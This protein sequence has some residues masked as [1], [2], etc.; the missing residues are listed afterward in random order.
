MPGVGGFTL[1]EVVMTMV[2][3]SVGL[4]SLAPVM[5][6]VVQGNRFAQN[7]TLATTLA[8]DR[9]EE[10]LNHPV[11]AQI[12]LA[13]YPSEAQG[14]IRGG[15]PKFTRF[16]RSVTVTDSLDVLGRSL[17]KSVTVTVTW[18]RQTGQTSQVTLHSRVSRF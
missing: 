13:N 7:I 5:L 11:Y 9:L 10:I 18:L 3:L 8:E 15:D 14:Q 12:T 1:V 2:L 17:L 6:A 16:A 4:L